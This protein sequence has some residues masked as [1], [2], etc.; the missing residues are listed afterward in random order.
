[1]LRLQ[2][3]TSIVDHRPVNCQVIKYFFG[4]KPEETE[5]E[6]EGV[7]LRAKR[8]RLWCGCWMA[9]R[10]LWGDLSAQKPGPLTPYFLSVQ[11]SSLSAKNEG[12]LGH[13]H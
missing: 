4:D 11:L 2:E 7:T 3:I 9:E 5:M 13:Q 8:P 6:T 10:T 1:M 12:A